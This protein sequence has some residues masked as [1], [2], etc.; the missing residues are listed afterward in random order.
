V[1]ERRLGWFSN[2]DTE[3]FVKLPGECVRRSLIV[4]DV[5]SRE[6]PVIWI[7]TSARRSKTEER[8]AI[9]DKET[10]HTVMAAAG[11]TIAHRRRPHATV[12]SRP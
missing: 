7:P 4:L 2:H 8:R 6:I 10:G 1:S 3:L 12:R 5:A 11:L 9:L